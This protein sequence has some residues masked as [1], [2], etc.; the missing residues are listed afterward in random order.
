MNGISLPYIIFEIQ[1]FG[2]EPL[3]LPFSGVSI[4]AVNASPCQTRSNNFH[5]RM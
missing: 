5:F 3:I 1:P 2:W 4:T